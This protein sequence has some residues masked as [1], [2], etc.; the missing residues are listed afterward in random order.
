[1][2]LGEEPASA[3][4]AEELPEFPVAPGFSRRATCARA[5]HALPLPGKREDHY[6]RELLWIG[7][8]GAPRDRVGAPLLNS[9]RRDSREVGFGWRRRPVKKAARGR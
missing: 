8:F 3:G 4:F 7:D 9:L 6:Q 1:M 2:T 5:R